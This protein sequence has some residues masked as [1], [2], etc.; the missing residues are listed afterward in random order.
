MS[1]WQNI[2]FLAAGFLAGSFLVFL[3]LLWRNKKE[4]MRIH[5]LADYLE[6]VNTGKG[7]VL[8]ALGEDDFSKLEDEIYKTVTFLYHTKDRAVQEKNDFAENLSNIAHQIK[9]PITAIHLSLQ[10]MKENSEGNH[11]EQVEKQLRR[12]ISRSCLKIPEFPWKYRRQGK[13]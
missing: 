6:Q 12:I 4:A 5:A 9:T 1:G 2:L 7:V 11:I 8:S 10:M 3:I 13:L